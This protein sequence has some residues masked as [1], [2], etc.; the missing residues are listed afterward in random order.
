MPKPTKIFIGQRYGNRVVTGVVGMS[1]NN[2][3]LYSFVCDC[4]F[5]GKARSTKLLNNPMH[6]GNCRNT[7]PINMVGTPTEH[8]DVL[9][10]VGKDRHG[11]LVFN[12]RCKFCGTEKI[13]RGQCLRNT[14]EPLCAICKAA[15]I[16]TPRNDIVGQTINGWLV[17]A[18]NGTNKHGAILYQCR[19]LSCGNTVERTA[20]SILRGN[21]GDCASCEPQYNF[22]SHVAFTEGTLPDGTHFL[23]D[24]DMTEAFASKRW[25]KKASGYI[26]SKKRGQCKKHLSHF[27]LGVG[28]NV[29]VD[30]INRNKTDNRRDNLRIVTAEQNALNK[31]LSSNN[32]TG[33]VGVCWVSSNSRY[34]ATIGKYYRKLHLGTFGDAKVAAAAYN[35]DAACL[36]GEYVGHLNDVSVPSPQF[37]A[38]IEEKCERFRQTYGGEDIG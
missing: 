29:I 25:H 20:G 37:A 12:C 13:L 38:Q 22:I 26:I 23:I 3:L 19:H 6:C 9:S 7:K 28:D 5:H 35:I 14:P 27:V 17:L 21:L 36:F 24:S 8:W 10:S 33:Y 1:P 11:A 31:S 4:G 15:H 18:Q 16:P 30:H 34:V 32:T 2:Q